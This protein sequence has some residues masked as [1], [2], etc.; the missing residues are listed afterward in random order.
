MQSK[1]DKERVQK[2]SN[3]GYSKQRIELRIK[4]KIL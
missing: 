3:A 2:S 4:I 1:R